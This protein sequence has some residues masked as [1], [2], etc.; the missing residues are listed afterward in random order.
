MCKEPTECKHCGQPSE[1]DEACESCGSFNI[2]VMHSDL[3]VG[4][5]CLTNISRRQW[6][7]T[8]SAHRSKVDGDVDWKNIVV[9]FGLDPKYEA[10][11]IYAEI[12]GL[13]E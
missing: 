2:V 1:K 6:D 9:L 11:A 7:D 10:K 5:L 12:P 4:I 8:M 3:P 13:D